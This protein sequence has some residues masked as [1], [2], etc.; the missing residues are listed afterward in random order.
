VAVTGPPVRYASL[1][2]GVRTLAR[3]LSIRSLWMSIWL[4]MGVAVVVAFAS[5]FIPHTPDPDHT[6]ELITRIIFASVAWAGVFG[7]MATVG[8]LQI[9]RTISSTYHGAMSWLATALGL[10]AF[11]IFHEIVVKDTELITTTYVAYAF[12]LWPFLLAGILFMKAGQT[13]KEATFKKLPENATYVDAVVYAAGLVSNPRDIDTTLDTLRQVTAR[14]GPESEELSP[15]DKQSLLRVYRSI[16]DY[17]VTKEPLRKL[18]KPG[19]RARLTTEFQSE[20]AKTEGHS[21]A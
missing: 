2:I 14:T 1:Y 11:A 15:T 7:V 18:T 17:L 6:A 8:A 12:S 5:I 16:E 9:K 19:L 21:P 13:L 20:L 3:Q 10:M 4:T